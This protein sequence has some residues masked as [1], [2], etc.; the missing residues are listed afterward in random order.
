MRYLYLVINKNVQ[1]TPK[2]FVSISVGENI[3][4]LKFLEL[5]DFLEG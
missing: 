2:N 1:K 5:K 4:I 3:N